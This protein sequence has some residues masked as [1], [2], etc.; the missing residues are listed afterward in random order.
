MNNYC[1]GDFYSYML[2]AV[3][4]QE[5]N[6]NTVSMLMD[7]GFGLWCEYKCNY[8]ISKM[9]TVCS[10]ASHIDLSQSTCAIEIIQRWAA[11]AICRFASL[12]QCKVGADLSWTLTG[13][14]P[15]L[16]LNAFFVGTDQ[17]T[18]QAEG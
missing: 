10:H 4:G 16:A 6:A 11:T 13:Q 15:A 9:E 5:V 18:L 2:A 12:L 14:V 3:Q 7:N 17:Q 8:C 1:I